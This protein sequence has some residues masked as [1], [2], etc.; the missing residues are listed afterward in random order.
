MAESLD[1][2]VIVVGA[3]PAGLLLTQ[4]LAQ[5]GVPVV[6]VEKSDKL[7]EQPRAT[8]YAAPAMAELLRAGVVEEMG[9]A[10]FHPHTI[11]WRL[12]DGT[13]L[14]GLDHSLTEGDEDQ[15]VCLPLN[16]LGQILYNK[17][18][19]QPNATI[20]FNH[21]VINSAQDEDSA[22]ITVSTPT[23]ERNLRARYIVGCDGANSKIRRMLF[24]DWEFPGKTWDV[25][26]VATNVYYDFYKYGY[27][28]ANFIIDPVHWYMASRISTDGMWRVSYGEQVGLTKDDLLANRDEKFRTMLPGHPE[29]DQYRITNFSPYKVHQRLAKSMRV[30]RFI[31]AADAAHL[32]NP[33]GGL[34]LTGGI[35]DVGGLFDCLVGIYENKAQDSILDKYDQI[36]REK[37][38][39]FINPISS[40]NIVRMHDKDPKTI[41][42]R[43]EFFQAIDKVKD[44]PEAKKEFLNGINVIKHDFTQYYKDSSNVGEEKSPKPEKPVSV[45]AVA[46]GSVAE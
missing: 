3:G 7:D 29:P 39:Q 43:D 6:L 24:G 35:V 12:L 15:M 40:S 38:E 27:E 11:C 2:W 23:G 8:H 41:M 18:K 9:Q 30:G 1:A 34:G 13:K 16:K 20:L 37:Y 10:G 46:A 28:D 25:Q 45:S 31:L 19:Q 22:S 36:R 26:V 5:K 33:F 44:D 32:C 17:V 4:L 42:Q 14:T 21:E